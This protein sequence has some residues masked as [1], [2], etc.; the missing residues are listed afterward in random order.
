MDDDVDVVRIVKG[1]RAA[2]E[3]GVVELPLGGSDLPDQVR[4][5]ASILFVAGTAAVC[6]EI[7]QI[8]PFEF[9]LWRQRQLA[10]LLAANQI[11]A[12]GNQRLDSLRPQGRNDVGRPRAPIESGE[13]RLLDR[14]SIHEVDDIDRERGGL[15]VAE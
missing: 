7:E 5:L 15:A 6:R 1:G 12:D 9:G 4:K 14:E 3:R 13:K 8:P 10:G 2:M 11:S